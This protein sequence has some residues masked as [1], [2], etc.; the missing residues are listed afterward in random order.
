MVIFSLQMNRYANSSWICLF[1]NFAACRPEEKAP[2]DFLAENIDSTVSP[3]ND[4][5]TYAN[6]G[7]IG[8]RFLLISPAG[9]SVIWFNWIFITG[10]EQSMKKYRLKIPLRQYIPKIGDFGLAVWIR[11]ELKNG[12]CNRFS[13]TS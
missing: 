11:P 7:W 8:K 3:A 13:Q 2:T 5:F 9:A 4:F 12:D 10:F 6:G 1:F